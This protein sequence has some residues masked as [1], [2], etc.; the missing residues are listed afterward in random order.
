MAFIFFHSVGNVIIPTDELHH[1]SRWLLH[2]Q[3]AT[4][5]EISRN[6]KSKFQL[7]HPTTS[8]FFWR[9]IATV[10]ELIW[11]DGGKM[12][13]YHRPAMAMAGTSPKD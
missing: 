5:R 3:P 7:S 12:A 10:E 13:R 11:A 8:V 2:H 6:T 4:N 9:K 1:F